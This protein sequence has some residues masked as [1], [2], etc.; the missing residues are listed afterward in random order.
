MVNSW[1]VKITTTRRDINL[2][3]IRTPLIAT[4]AGLAT[5]GL[6]FGT[7]AAAAEPHGRLL[8]TTCSFS[9]FQAA[10]QQH[11]PELAANPERLGQFETILNRSVEERDA[12]REEKRA[13]KPEISPEKRAKWAEWKNSPEGQA[14]IAAMRTVLDTCHQF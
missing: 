9:Q 7:G 13:N 6:L 2:A 1:E 10:A 3:A 11:A 4:F 5:A 8:D 14:N 12:Q